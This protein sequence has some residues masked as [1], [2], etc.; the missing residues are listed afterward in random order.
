M[1]CSPASAS[2]RPISVCDRSLPAGEREDRPTASLVGRGGFS[3]NVSG[4]SLSS[5]LR[6][7]AV[8]A[9][10]VTAPRLVAAQVPVPT[11]EFAPY[12]GVRQITNA[13][14]GTPPAGAYIMRRVAVDRTGAFGGRI[15]V[16][17][18]AYSATPGRI[19]IVDPGSGAQS[20][21]GGA[22]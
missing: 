18:N 6:W 1:R 11:A 16:A 17:T 3:M 9:V 22:D 5:L 10:A 14:P 8:L 21:L 13:L 12:I 2:V 7:T 19:D 20:P 15:A 4:R